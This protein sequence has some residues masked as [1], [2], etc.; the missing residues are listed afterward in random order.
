MR[1]FFDTNVLVS[2]LVA[3]GLCAELYEAVVLDHQLIIGEPVVAELLRILQDKLH[4][5]PAKVAKVRSELQ[6]FEQAP[7]SDA[8]KVSFKRDP[9]DEPILSCAVAAKADV[10][11]TGDKAI[12]AL[13]GIG[14]VP[15]CSPRELWFKLA[16][17]EN[18]ESSD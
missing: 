2:A 12:L 5:P 18:Q 15:V 4:V 17:P 1:I 3:R 8:A 7:A 11:V 10:F 13:G 6:R 16:T 9:T 14:G